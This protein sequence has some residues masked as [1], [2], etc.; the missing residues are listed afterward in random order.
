[1]IAPILSGSRTAS[2]EVRL[3][4][5]STEDSL[6]NVAV[7]DPSLFS[8]PYDLHLC[9]GLAAAGV[10]TTLF[11]RKPRTGENISGTG[12]RFEPWFYAVSEGFRNSRLTPKMMKNPLKA[13]EHCLDSA[14]LA[15][16]LKTQKIS[17]AHFQW[18]ALPTID[19]F[20]VKSLKRAGIRVVMTVHDTVPFNDSPSSR[21]Q[22][23][24]WKSTLE[25]F[26]A[27]IVHTQQS[28]ANL[29]SMKIGVPVFV[30]PHGLLSFG[31]VPVEQ[32]ISGKL[33]FLFFGSIKPYKGID[34]LLRAFQK[35]NAARTAEL[36]IVGNCPD[37]PGEVLGLIKEL[38]I[39]DCVQFECR[40]F[41]DA[42]VPSILA[43]GDVMVFPYRRI[44]GSGALLTALAYKK[45]VIATDV[46]MFRELLASP[47][48]LVEANSVEAIADRL[49]EL[50]RDPSRVDGL[51]DVSIRT[52]ERIPTWGEI[53]A[54]TLKVYESLR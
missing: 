39:E 43:Q 19:R 40:F 4:R 33:R 37:G 49:G 2:P 36:I 9:E 15:H 26:D 32:E 47:V 35:A 7:I 17:A 18:I 12:F 29:E 10:R 16:H 22:N 23:L 21:G 24:G 54:A 3:S 25:L 34:I 11:G 20:T 5:M 45:P 31:P 48:A 38:A 42:E 27:L 52:A 1:M 28:K 30:V 13:A 8:L 50:I 14:R 44:D 51:R 53:G 41:H 46:G 6:I